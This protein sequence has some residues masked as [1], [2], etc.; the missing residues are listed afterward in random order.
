M[1]IK[2]GKDYILLVWKAPETRKRHVVGQLS[3]NGQY[4]FSYLSSVDEAIKEGFELVI[5]F[6]D[7]EITYKSDKLFS[8]FSS[9]L[10]DRKRRGIE[11]ILKRYDLTEYDEYKLLKR[12]G[13]RLPIDGLEFVDPIPEEGDASRRF[14]IAGPRYYIG[15]QGTTCDQSINID[16]NEELKIV[17]QPDNKYDPNA[18]QILNK[19]CELLGYIPRHFSETICKRLHNGYKYKCKV[20]EINKN[21]NCN[22]CIE[23]IL[24]IFK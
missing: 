1:S 14:Y 15:C 12:S 6:S 20:I 21:T 10:P 4:E 18:L 22:E 2:E 13:A 17:Q 19:K 8:I 11:E 16:I 24:D 3:K 9:R 23:V 5:P 7:I